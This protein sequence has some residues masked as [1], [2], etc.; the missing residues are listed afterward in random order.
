MAKLLK[1]PVSVIKIEES[2]Y[3]LMRLSRETR[4]KRVKESMSQITGMHF[5]HVSNQSNP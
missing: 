4:T 3:L 5:L 2:P 1:V